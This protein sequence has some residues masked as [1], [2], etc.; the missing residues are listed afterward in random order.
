ML[1]QPLGSLGRNGGASIFSKLWTLVLLVLSLSWA[2]PDYA[3][4]AAPRN[5]SSSPSIETRRFISPSA[6][7]QDLF[8]HDVLEVT[9]PELFANEFAVLK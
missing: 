7:L 9:L 1:T 3:L 2:K 5:D 8:L 6:P 4:K